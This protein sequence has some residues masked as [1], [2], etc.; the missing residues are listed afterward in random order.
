MHVQ[1][2]MCQLWGLRGRQPLFPGTLEALPFGTLGGNFAN[3]ANNANSSPPSFSLLQEPPAGG[4]KKHQIFSQGRGPRAQPQGH[5]RK[6]GDPRPHPSLARRAGGS[7]RGTP[8]SVKQR[9]P[10][11]RRQDCAQAPTLVSRSTCKHIEARTANSHIGV[12]TDFPTRM[13][14]Q[15]HPCA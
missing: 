2:D 15:Q 8:H 4:E 7:S 1:P 13:Q 11:P 14:W 6:V 3:N 5:S 12:V 9:P 10:V